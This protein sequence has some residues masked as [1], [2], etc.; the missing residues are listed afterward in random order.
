MN[1]NDNIAY[2]LMIS[3][4]PKTYHS[5]D[6]RNYFSQ[7]I[8]SGKFDCFHFRHRPE[9]RKTQ[10]NKE[11]IVHTN[12]NEEAHST[13]C[14]ITKVKGIYIDE[15]ITLY[16][17][18]HWVDRSDESLSTLCCISIIK[19]S[20]TNNGFHCNYFHISQLLKNNSLLYINICICNF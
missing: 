13:T 9:I 11:T 17:R 19:I 8:E 16:N 12:Y 20:P 5:S 3:N 18:K 1:I 2:Y 4:I 15:L 6:L 10:C 7:F 14:S